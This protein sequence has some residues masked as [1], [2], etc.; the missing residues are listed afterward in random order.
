METTT[1]TGGLVYGIRLRRE[2][3]Y[4]YVGITTKTA[5]RR[6]H[7]HLRVAVEGRK[8]P[9]YDWLRKFDPSEVT[10]DELDWVEGLQEL[11]QAEIDW[12][13]YLRRE[14]DRLLNLSEGGL[15]P[16][17]VVWT[18]EMRE[19][20]RIRSTGRKIVRQS[21]PGAPFYGKNHSDEQKEK[22]SR[23][24]KGTN[25]GPE[26]PNFGKFGPEHP[27]FGHAMSEESKQALSETRKGAG[28]PNF[29]KTASAET[30]AKMSAV[31]KGRPMPSSQ[32]NAHTRHHTN[33]GIMNPVCKH[34][35]ED[36]AKLSSPSE[37]EEE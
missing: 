12:I 3:E 37:S 25:A 15:G 28:N 14:G 19:A 36:A 20:A 2:F 9:F 18:E 22:W 5:S 13:S 35:V 29:G 33:K 21:G 7:Q 17:G 30:R 1:A 34:C 16:T 6:F 23:E 4:R 11:G 24:R 32:R 8:T 27:R 31:R 10:V 26:N